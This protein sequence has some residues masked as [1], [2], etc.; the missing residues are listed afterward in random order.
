MHTLGCKVNQYETQVMREILLDN[1]FHECISRDIADIYI[2][3]TCTVT[4]HADR[5][6]RYWVGLFHRANP[7]ARIVVTGCY[8]EQNSGDISF[9]PGVSVLKNDEKYTIARL[10]DPEN[11][12]VPSSQPKIT[13]FKGHVKAFVKVQDGCENSCSYCKVPLVRGELKSRR[14][15]EIL[16]EIR[17]L[18]AG[19]FKE[20]VLTGI[21]LGA[22]GR[23]FFP[24]E[25]AE[26]SGVGEAGI[27]DLLKAISGIEGDFRVRLSS[28][29]AR[30]VT[31]GLISQVADNPRI[32]KHLHIPLQSGDDD[33]LRR[34]NR[35]Y[36]AAEYKALA[37]RI[38]SKMP[39]AAIT[40][41]VLIGFPG[42][43]EESFKRTVAFIKDV[44]P[45]RTHIF[46]FS[47]R[48]GTAAYDMGEE[49]SRDVLKRRFHELNAAALSASYIYRSRFTGKKLSVLAETKREK[50]SGLLT[51]YSDNYI[52]VMFEGQDSIMGSVVPVTVKELTLMHTLGEYDGK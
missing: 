17:S 47:R 3:N 21:C 8:V 50:H 26:R 13:G 27:A 16:S 33:I 2:L 9:L 35:P 38:R 34:M 29:E 31:D 49:L 14:L 32:C 24:G 12:R 52:R 10:L 48:E 40:T 5:E 20:I 1:G 44:L 15:D 43:T 51:G 36:S 23:D 25:L 4:Q 28:I 11:G 22:W 37:G 46:T 30:Y 39:D 18:V 19:G 41:D 6:S 45:M 42:E 7:R